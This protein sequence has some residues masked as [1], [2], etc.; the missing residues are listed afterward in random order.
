MLKNGD[1]KE[2][3]LV[4]TSITNWGSLLRSRHTYA[5]T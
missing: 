5:Y 4:E 2:L 1:Q 3:C